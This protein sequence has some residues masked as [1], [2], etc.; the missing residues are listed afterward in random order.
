[1]E[2]D[3]LESPGTFV[4]FSWQSFDFEEDEPLPLDV[5][6]ALFTSAPR[7]ELTGAILWPARNQELLPQE[8]AVD[9]AD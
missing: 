3:E 9:I 6:F 5:A 8:Q 7:H 4:D 2:V 1:M